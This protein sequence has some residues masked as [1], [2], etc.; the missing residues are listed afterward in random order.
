ML[1]S[2]SLISKNKCSRDKNAEVNEKT[3]K[4]EIKLGMDLFGR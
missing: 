3:Y 4:E 2:E 1:G